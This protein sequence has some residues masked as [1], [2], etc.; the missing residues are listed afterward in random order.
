MDKQSA[1]KLFTEI[2]RKNPEEID[3][4]KAALLIA[5]EEYPALSIEA[6]L[7]K[8]SDLGDK[9]ADRVAGQAGEDVRI[10]ALHDFLFLEYGLRGNSEDYYDPRNSFLN[11][12]LDRRKGIPITLCL[13]YK[14]IAKRIGLRMDAI[15]LPGHLVLRYESGGTQSY[16]DPFNPAH[17]MDLDGCH[18]L[19][20][21][22]YQREV[23]LSQEQLSPIDNR[24]YLVRILNNL[25]GIYR[26]LGDFR[27]GLLALERI[28]I[29]S[30]ADRSIQTELAALKQQWDTFRN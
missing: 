29:L 19:V 17:K 24:Q 4:P 1:R 23:E 22:V 9:V 2:V 3:L 5:A 14:E 28:A 12:V 13:V 8:L 7:N 11:E 18:E 10:S 25:S 15:G 26:R 21:Q 27:R 20:R 30:P 16:V 6:Y